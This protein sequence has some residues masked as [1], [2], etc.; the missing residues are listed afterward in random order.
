MQQ[1]FETSPDVVLRYTLALQCGLKS[2]A[3]QLTRNND[4]LLDLCTRPT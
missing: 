2:Y 3:A 4:Y 1:F